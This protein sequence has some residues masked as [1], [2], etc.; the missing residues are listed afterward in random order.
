MAQKQ[1][2]KKKEE[3]LKQEDKKEN[4]QKNNQ[5]SKKEN[6]QES[7]QGKNTKVAE[8]ENKEKKT[9]KKDKEE[10]NKETIKEEKQEIEEAAIAP[11]EENVEIE[12]IKETIKKEIPEEEV[13]KIN[14]S[15]FQNILIA[16]LIIVYFIFLNLGFK[17]IK[18]DVYVT[19]LKVF[20]MCILLTA[21]ALIENAYKKERGDLAIYGIEMIVLAITTVALI[22]VNL[23]LSTRYMYIVNA[24]SY[25]FAIYYLIKSIVIYFKRKKQYFVRDMKEIMKKEE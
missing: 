6:K 8:K 5:E 14:K 1:S 21:I 4:K 18:T 3:E 13:K 16:L 22:Y 10:K 23:M 20:S 7:K 24:I 12:K 25:I 11:K 2:A 17:N 15:I 9:K 19:D